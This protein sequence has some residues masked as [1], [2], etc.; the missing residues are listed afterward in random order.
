[1]NNKKETLEKAREKFGK[2]N[3]SA[4]HEQKILLA[5]YFTNAFHFSTP[6]I[7]DCLVQN[8]KRGFA[9]KLTEKQLLIEK[10]IYSY[11]PYFPKKILVLSKQGREFLLFKLPDTYIWEGKVAEGHI[12]H[13]YL[14]QIATLH[15]LKS[16][17]KDFEVFSI[18]KEPKFTNKIYDSYL[19]YKTK[20]KK[21]RIGIEVDLTRKKIR[22]IN[23][24]LFNIYFDLQNN[25]VDEVYFIFPKQHYR[26]FR[27]QYEQ[28]LNQ[29]VFLYEK[30]QNRYRKTFKSVQYSPEDR[31]KIHF[32]S[33]DIP[34]QI[35]PKQG[36]L[37][38]EIPKEILE[39]FELLERFKQE[40]LIVE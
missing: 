36:I 2:Q 5:L 25:L 9:K 39:H 26:L 30:E 37:E 1:M 8:K 23:N 18:A 24:T 38:D 31:E 10:D 29:K 15:K 14:V 28:V 7:I 35:C 6:S 3:R 27:N 4:R 40:D 13:D 33:I 19:S 20:D 16:I 22:E 34:P 11:L 17:L 32:E 21:E 12:F